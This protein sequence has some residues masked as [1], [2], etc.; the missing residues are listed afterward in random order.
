MSLQYE[1]P[2]DGEEEKKT[3]P[4]PEEY[5]EQQKRTIRARSYWFLGFGILTS[6]FLL[7]RLASGF[8]TLEDLFHNIFFVL[9][10]F[11]II[12]GAWGFYYA[13]KLTL[14]DLIP[15][16]E[17]IAFLRQEQLTKPYY[18]YILIA[19]IVAVMLCQITTGIDESIEAAG[20]VKPDFLQKGDYWRILTGGAMH[21]SIR[22]TALEV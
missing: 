22:F 7:F 6:G 17:A 15:S 4:T 20:F 3:Q 10:L 1:K 21:G 14:E 5:L 13:R 18:T 19:S 2:E 11:L 9:G 8:A 16:P 12:G